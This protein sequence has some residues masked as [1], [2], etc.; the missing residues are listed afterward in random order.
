LTNIR[1]K[2]FHFFNEDLVPG[3][4]GV[5]LQAVFHPPKSGMPNIMT[6]LS[7]ATDNDTLHLCGDHLINIA[8]QPAMLFS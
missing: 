1:A 8:H 5:L 6:S 3:S 4:V 7:P 2:P